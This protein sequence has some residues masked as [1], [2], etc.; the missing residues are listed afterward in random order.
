[1]FGMHLLEETKRFISIIR[2]GLIRMLADKSNTYFAYMEPEDRDWCLS[3][4][5][6][7]FEKS[8]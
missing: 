6:E 7:L 4:L 3:Y 8:K 1:M 5:D 2:L